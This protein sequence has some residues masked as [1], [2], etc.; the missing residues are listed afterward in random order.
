MGGGAQ[1]IEEEPCINLHFDNEYLN[2]HTK[3]INYE[4]NVD[5]LGSNLLFTSY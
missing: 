2:T 3:S 1:I 4:K 5:G